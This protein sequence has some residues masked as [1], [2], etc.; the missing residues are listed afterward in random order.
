MEKV[1]YLGSKLV[2]V[3]KILRKTIKIQIKTQRRLKNRN[4]DCN[5]FRYKIK[6]K[7]YSH[8]IKIGK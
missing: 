2:V 3:L 1:N 8:K 6:K 4:L 5:E 7:F